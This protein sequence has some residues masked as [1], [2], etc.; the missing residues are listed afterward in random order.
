MTTY[1]SIYIYI[2]KKL[3]IDKN[4]HTNILNNYSIFVNLFNNKK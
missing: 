2:F 3:Y 1:I 4:I